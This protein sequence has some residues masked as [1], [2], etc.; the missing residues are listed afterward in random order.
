MICEKEFSHYGEKFVC[1]KNCNMQYMA[2]KKL[3]CNNPDFKSD[4]DIS[5]TCKECSGNFVYQQNGPGSLKQ[6]CSR[7]CWH[8][9]TKDKEIIENQPVD[10]HD[11]S[12]CVLCGTQEDRLFVHHIDYDKNNCDESNLI[13]LCKK[14]HE[15]TSSQSS[16]WEVFL[17]AMISGSKLVRK[18]WGAEIHIVNNEHYCL[19]YLVFF[20]GTYF[21]HHYHEAKKE[22][23][24]C[25]IGEFDMLLES[26]DGEVAELTTF[27]K[28][29]KVQVENG[30]IHQLRAKK[31]SILVEV[32]T[33]S[34]DED[35]FKDRNI[36]PG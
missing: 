26:Q 27:R 9:S 16:F 33:Q 25:L 4:K 15:I 7:L 3:G 13:C 17:T 18:E 31:N 12:A 24:H 2:Q 1:S 32:S 36:I 34:F 28:G 29:D 11:V 23:W 21:S 30:L 8:K 6:Y 20:A 19:K 14:C 5:F 22:A 10:K 35:S